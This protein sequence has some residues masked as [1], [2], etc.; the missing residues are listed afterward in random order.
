MASDIFLKIHDFA[1]EALG[2]KV[3]HDFLKLGTDFDRVGD[4]F[5]DLVADAMAANQHKH[6]AG[7]KYEA[8]I[9]HDV[10]TIGFDFIKLGLDTLKLDDVLHKFDDVILKFAD[11]S[12]KPDTGGEIAA[13]SDQNQLKLSDDFLKLDTDLNNTGLGA[14]K[15][16]LDFLKVNDTHTDNPNQNFVALATDLHTIDASLGSVGVDFLNLGS[17]Y[18]ILGGLSDSQ[19]IDAAFIKLSD[20]SAGVGGD[21]HKVS[22]DFFKIA[23]D[24]DQSTDTNLTLKIDELALKFASDFK[25]LD[26]DMHKLDLDLKLLGDDSLKL[27]NAL[28]AV[29]QPPGPPD[30][31]GIPDSLHQILQLVHDFSLL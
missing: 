25:V 1:G 10:D 20:D 26:T 30:N 27:A 5:S 21:F 14:I 13:A 24:I 19:K 31:H 18:K 6:L 4:A 9:K 12:L 22:D 29:Q 15:L 2:H 23:T 8:S 3:D 17:D 11:Q 16:G 28:P 7:V